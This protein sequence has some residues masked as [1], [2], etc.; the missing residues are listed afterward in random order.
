MRPL[1]S[2][3]YGRTF[4]YLLNALLGVVFLFPFYWTVI[5][6]LKTPD[7][8]LDYPP[9]FIPN[10]ATLEN[11]YTVISRQD[12]RL[13]YFNSLVIALAT[14]FLVLLVS[15][16]AG[17]GFAKLNLRWRELLFFSI[18]I[19]LMIPHQSLLIP[20]F[21]I[22]QTFGLINTREG[23][24]LI[25]TTFSLPVSI[26]LLR[27]ACESIPND[28]VESARIDGCGDLR[29]WWNI[30][31]PLI[32]PSLATLAIL[33]F[34]GSWNEFLVALIFTTTD[35]MKTVPV[36]LS[37][38]LGVYGIH[39][40]NLTAVTVLSFIPVF[41]IFVFGQRFIVSG[42]TSGAIK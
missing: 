13:W 35:E 28:L 20:L 29:I 16:L 40:E 6:A 25:Y 34:L 3:A 10:P 14:V 22:L 15:S 4:F 9:G 12:F 38:L 37:V 2:D 39:W 30:I 33:T 11:F 24:T 23:L 26:F 21:T 41:V 27:N 17:Y 32:K 18:L 1:F 36:G 42:L 19:S 31:L 7:H 8:I 5:T